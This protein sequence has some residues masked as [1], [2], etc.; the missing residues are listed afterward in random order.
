V[1]WLG[2]FGLFFSIW[3]ALSKPQRLRVGSWQVA[4]GGGFWLTHVIESSGPVTPGL[5]G[6]AYLPYEKHIVKL[7][8]GWLTLF[9]LNAWGLALLWRKKRLDALAYEERLR[10]GYGVASGIHRRRTKP[11]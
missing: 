3:T 1:L 5:C 9:Y 7:P 4:T 10:T 2:L 6:L 11:S 8:G